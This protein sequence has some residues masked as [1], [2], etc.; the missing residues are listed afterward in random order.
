MAIF[1]SLAVWDIGSSVGQLGGM[2]GAGCF[3]G[4]GKNI[5]N[6]FIAGKNE[7]VQE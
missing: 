3:S 6:S 7:G 2:I 4:A 1:L 5:Y